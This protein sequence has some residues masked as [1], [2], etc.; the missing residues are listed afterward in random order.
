MRWIINI[1]SNYLRMMI[2]MVIVFMLT[3]YIISKLGIEVYGLWAIALSIAG[4]AG[5]MDFGFATA[6]VKYVAESV[7]ANDRIRRNS[8]IST[9]FYAYIAIALLAL[10]LVALLSFAGTGWMPFAKVT[11]NVAEVDFTTVLIILGMGVALSLPASVFKAAVIGCGRMDIANLVEL[12][13]VLLNAGLIVLLL[14]SGYG[15]QGLAWA[16][17]FNLSATAILLIPVA[18]RLLPEFSISIS[19]ISTPMLRE[20]LSF[21]C[22]AFIANI[23]V[24]A[25]LRLDTLVIGAFLP[26]AAVA[27]YAVAAKVAE[28][29]LL[30]NKQF[31][32]ALMPLISQAKGGSDSATICRVLL[33]G[34]RFLLALALPFIALLYLYAPEIFAVWLGNEF[35]DSIP[36]LRILLIAVLCSTLQLNAANVL[37]MTGNHRFVAFTML[38]AALVNFG[39]SISL[40][41]VWGLPGVA[42]ATLIAAF[43]IEMAIMLPRAC[44]SLDITL[45][46]FFTSSVLPAL[47]P[48]IL[49]LLIAVPLSISFVAD[50]LL[51][52]LIQ[53]GGCALI[54]GLIFL[55]IGLKTMERKLLIK[56]LYSLLP[57]FFISHF[58]K[59][60]SHA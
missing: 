37:G 40:V 58:N 12:A 11:G 21:S 55:T 59:E 25:I 10:T 5:L 46:H 30:L 15:I 20:L 28:Y 32:N 27:I 18:Y 7:G 41:L 42:M 45:S 36:L 51:L 47:K 24:L 17:A 43:F 31:S 6:A 19:L 50:S 26:L 53:A 33:D 9:L 34:T 1:V 8:I 49:M 16:A 38:S 35:D 4:L 39:L 54:Y 14:E 52:V 60:N 44:R 56:Y 13:V 3:P 48:V 23:A 57:H 22:Y 2:S 29:V